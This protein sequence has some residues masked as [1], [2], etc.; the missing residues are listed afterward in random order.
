VITP[1]R[2]EMDDRRS[3]RPG[4][5]NG[6]VLLD[7]AWAERLGVHRTAGRYRIR[8]TELVERLMELNQ[9]RQLDP[10]AARTTCRDRASERL[11]YPPVSITP[12]GGPIHLS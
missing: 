2:N 4:P 3:R 7:R 10:A 12:V 5:P 6:W 9:T 11:H 1:E 8:R